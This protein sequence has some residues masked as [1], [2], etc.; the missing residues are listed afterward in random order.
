[1]K[2]QR[3]DIKGSLYDKPDLMT[4]LRTH[5][6]ACCEPLATMAERNDFVPAMS[7]WFTFPELRQGLE[8]PCTSPTKH[9][10][11]RKQAFQRPKIK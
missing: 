8:I 3:T 1:M 7:N 6:D 10:C 4:A 5:L 2:S 9:G 11:R